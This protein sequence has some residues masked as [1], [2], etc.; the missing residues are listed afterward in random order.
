[1]CTIKKAI[2][3]FGS[4]VRCKKDKKDKKEKK[5]KHLCLYIDVQCPFTTSIPC[6]YEHGISYGL[7][8]I[9]HR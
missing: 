2:T 6:S 4:N 3:V 9:F 5:E 8:P 7:M 1:M